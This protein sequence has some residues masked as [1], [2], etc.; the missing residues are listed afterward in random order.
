M[1]DKAR[2]IGLVSRPPYGPFG[3][4]SA[5]I[6]THIGADA[7]EGDLLPGFDPYPYDPAAARQEMRLSTY[8]RNGD[9]QCDEPACRGVLA[10]VLASGAVPDQA[11]AI[12]ANLAGLGIEL[13]LDL[14]QPF[15]DFFRR[16]S[17][18]SQR[19]PMGIGA[20][21]GKDF[22]N[23]SGW[24]PPLFAAASLGSLSHT[25]LGAT[26]GQL[27]GWGY[28]VTSV[29]SVDDRLE[30]CATR[31]GSAQTECW[32]ELDQYLMT[33]V[34]PWVPYMFVNHVQVVSE[35]VVGYSFDQFGAQPA[36]DRLA[37]A[38]GSD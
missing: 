5:E 20:G 35:R 34:V 28:S 3:T 13:E 37:L 12:R 26:A 8:D 15:P 1:I 25:L 14:E 21:W 4:S 2:L 36:L 32:A 16:L 38:P 10:I 24:F 18:P 29:P 9:G 33:E 30:A 22:P 17:D 19:I 6:A 11:R 27:R 7:V 31:W 23:G